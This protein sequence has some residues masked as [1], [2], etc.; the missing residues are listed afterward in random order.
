[1]LLDDDELYVF[2]CQRR[3][4]LWVSLSK[5]CT[6]GQR[7]GVQITTI[8]YLVGYLFLV[9]SPILLL[10]MDNSWVRSISICD[11]NPVYH[12]LSSDGSRN[13]EHDSHQA[14][15][16]WSIISVQKPIAGHTRAVWPTSTAKLDLLVKASK[17]ILIVGGTGR[18]RPLVL[19]E[20]FPRLVCDW[21]IDPWC[22]CARILATWAPRQSFTP[23]D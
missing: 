19:G 8:S 23:R 22:A 21:V 17:L 12:W 2:E 20:L 5:R 3:H 4:G 11:N 6:K 14:C 13:T 15:E 18:D 10:A 7:G 1:V 9:G 16:H